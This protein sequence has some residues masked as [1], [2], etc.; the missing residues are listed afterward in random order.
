[1]EI[2]GSAPARDADN[3]DVDG[4]VVHGQPVPPANAAGSLFG[5]VGGVLMLVTRPAKTLGRRGGPARTAQPAGECHSSLSVV[6]P[7]AVDSRHLARLAPCRPDLP[8]R[9]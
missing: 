3:A 6:V 1:M 4:T 7:G 2:R 5:G 8:L 9:A